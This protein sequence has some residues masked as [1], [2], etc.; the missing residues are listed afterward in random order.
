MVDAVEHDAPSMARRVRITPLLF[1]VTFFAIGLLGLGGDFEVD[2]T[3][4][5]V[6]LLAAAGIATGVTAIRSIRT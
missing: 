1:G 2:A 4:L 3:W 5:W 6:G